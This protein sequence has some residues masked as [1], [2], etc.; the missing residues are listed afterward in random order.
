MKERPFEIGDGVVFGH[1]AYCSH[2]P[3][4]WKEGRVVN[5]AGNVVKI[6]WRNRFGFIRHSW[7]PVS[8]VGASSNWRVER[9]ERAEELIKRTLS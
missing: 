6:Q 8:A 4:T 7:I 9:Q 3:T 1:T 5:I 2:A